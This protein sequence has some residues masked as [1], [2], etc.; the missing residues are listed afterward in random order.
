ML[1]KAKIYIWSH[2][3]RL[4][5]VSGCILLGA[6]IGVLAIKTQTS[7]E[8]SYN[9]TV[10]AASGHRIDAP[11]ELGL[12]QAVYQI[13]SVS[14]TPE[15]QGTWERSG[16]ILG[17]NRLIFTPE[18]D[19][20]PDQ[21]YKVTLN[22]VQRIAFGAH[23]TEELH[24]TTE[25]A[26]SLTSFSLDEEEVVPADGVVTA[27]FNGSVQKLRKLSLKVGDVTLEQTID[28]SGE[29]VAWK[30]KELLPQGKNT[31]LVLYD[32]LTDETLIDR[33]SEVAPEPSIKTP[34]T[35]TNFGKHETAKIVFGEAI[36]RDRL[37]EN[38]ITFSISG[39]GAW[40]DDVTYEFTPDTVAPGKIYEYTL[41]KGLRTVRGGVLVAS[42]T[43]QF[44]TPGYVGAYIT[45]RGGEVAQAVQDVRIAFNQ[46]VVHKS[47][48]E[49]LKISHGAIGA[50]R[51]QG[52]TMVVP[53]T[54]LGYQKS[55]T[56]TVAAGV[57]PE[58]GIR[59]TSALR[60][61]FTTEAQIVKLNVPFYYQQFAQSCEAASVRM[62][63]AYRGTSA[64]DWQIL[65]KFG[66]NPRSLDKK[67]NIWDDPQKQ[68]VGDV[69]GNQGKG[70][71]WGV[72]AEPVAAAVRSYGREATV[73]YGVSAAFVAGQIHQNRPVVLWGIWDES[74]TQKTWKTP[75]GRTISGPIPMHVRLVVGVK[76]S[77]SNP[78]GFYVNDPITGPTYWT[79]EYLQHNVNR[80]GGAN[81]AVAIH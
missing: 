33:E 40:K 59:N 8:V 81:Q 9:A 75:E 6:G 20:V 64:T 34:V 67:N 16:T 32:A 80:A 36:D 54:K 17:T 35:S 31:R 63:L 78:V 19:F 60:H 7:L 61:T 44:S 74:A 49:R 37:P 45:P 57:E 46:T 29:R 24:F 56:I 22:D 70:T 62:A 15:V 1:K 10:P 77:P 43:K 27:V 12:S 5:L 72:Y 14:I 4:A 13:G 47:A 53:V 76:G 71:G 11:L 58:F 26:P 3:A 25:K 79:A 28:P 38:A 23:E 73:R 39:K 30:A 51:W 50:I 42:Q 2:K 68:F 21:T 55:V 18:G 65:Q 69:K 52:T 66:Y 48:E 41:A